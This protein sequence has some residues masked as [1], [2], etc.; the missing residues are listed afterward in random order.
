MLQT[1]LFKNDHLDPFGLLAPQTTSPGRSDRLRLAG[2]DGA[3][4]GGGGT[5]QHAH[6]SAEGQGMAMLNDSG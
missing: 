4:I 5:E 6:S 1:E 3:Q 2:I